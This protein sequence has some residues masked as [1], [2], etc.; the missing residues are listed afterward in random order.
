MTEKHPMANMRL[1][2]AND[3]WICSPD[4]RKTCDSIALATT[5]NAIPNEAPT[6]DHLIKWK[7]FILPLYIL[8]IYLHKHKSNMK[9]ILIFTLLLIHMVNTYGQHWFGMNQSNYSGPHLFYFN[10]ALTTSSPRATTI[11][12]FSTGFHFENNYLTYQLPFSFGQWI[13]GNVPSAYKNSQ[14]KIDFQADWFIE[15]LDGSE[16]SFDMMAESRGSSA[17][18][19]FDRRFSVGFFNTTRV[20]LQGHQIHQDLARIFR[21]G[22]DS[23]NIIYDPPHQIK[24]GDTYGD[25]RF[26]VHLNSYSELG[27]GAAAAIVNNTYTKISIS[28]NVKYLMGKGTAFVRNNGVMFQVA[29]VDSIVF[30]QTNIEYGYAQPENFA[31]LRY[32]NFFNGKSAGTGLGY[33]LSAAIE[34]KKPGGR[35][36]RNIKVQDVEYYVKGGVSIVDMGKI[37]YDRKV[38][39]RRFTND[40]PTSWVPGEAFANAWNGGLSSGL[41]YTDSLVNNMFQTGEL[42]T[43]YTTLPT[44][45]TFF[46]DLRIIPRFFVG[47]QWVQSL[48]K[49]DTPGLRRPSATTVVPRFETQKFE[50]SVPMSLYNDY[51]NATLGFFIRFGPFLMGSDNLI[52]SINTSSFKG[53]NYYAG[54]VYG[55]ENSKKEME[56]GKRTF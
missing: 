10:T 22:L 35:V 33:D 12:G 8:V 48:K 41:E 37:T 17:L 18:Y 32:I 42:S 3:R 1:P 2:D 9:K 54:L 53:I 34:L 50:V 16:K 5:Y 27:V 47:L 46:G 28:G 19:N 21:H 45:L 15:N 23:Q 38:V 36:G 55:F 44:A 49:K 6:N 26:S 4:S 51:R 31:A 29:G 56:S 30:G 40:Q 13:T 24:I 52:S 14:G 25:N 20:A 11:N 7:S 39:H 43:L